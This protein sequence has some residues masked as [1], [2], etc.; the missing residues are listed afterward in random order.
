MV[1]N[2][3]LSVY[4]HSKV[5]WSGAVWMEIRLTIISLRFDQEVFFFT[6]RQQCTWTSF[7][8]AYEADV[9]LTVKCGFFLR[10]AG[11][12]HNFADLN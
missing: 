6:T 8:T 4:L 12:R 11:P 1:V 2:T 9:I 5:R 7:V 3:K 10:S